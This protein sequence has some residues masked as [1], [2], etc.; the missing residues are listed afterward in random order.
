MF[1]AAHVADIYR[2]RTGRAHRLWGN[3]TL[4][5]SAIPPLG[6]LPPEADLSDMIYVQA[7]GAVLEA[8]IA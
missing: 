1:A 8:L 2:K 3:G 6:P 7:L 5:A 4:Y